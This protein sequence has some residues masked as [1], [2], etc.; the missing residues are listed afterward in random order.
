MGRVV[1][2]IA[3]SV[4]SVLVPKFVNRRG[5]IARPD[6]NHPKFRLQR[7]EQFSAKHSSGGDRLVRKI[8]HVPK[9]VPSSNL[10]VEEVAHE[11]MR[12][13]ALAPKG[14]QLSVRTGRLQ[15]K[16]LFALRLANCL[17]HPCTSCWTVYIPKGPGSLARDLRDRIEHSTDIG[18]VNNAPIMLD[19]FIVIYRP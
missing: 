18:F 11:K 16:D 5:P 15:K 4:E 7:F 13:E 19:A 8:R 10:A 3:C 14:F 2:R 17:R 6:V 9:S 12:R 1:A